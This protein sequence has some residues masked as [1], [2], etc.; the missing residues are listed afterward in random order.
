M[1]SKPVRRSL[2][3]ALTAEFEMDGTDAEALVDSLCKRFGNRKEIDDN[4]LGAQERSVLYTLEAKKLVA[5]RR[6]QNEDNTFREFYWTFA[7]PILDGTYVP[8]Q[9]PSETKPSIYDTLPTDVWSEH[10]R[11]REL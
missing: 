11:L 8:Q 7:Q 4:L 10:A 2:L 6:V 5:F 1:V 9:K 3:K